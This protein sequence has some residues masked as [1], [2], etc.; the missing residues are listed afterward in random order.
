MWVRG[1]FEKGRGDVVRM[2]SV[3]MGHA[4]IIFLFKIFM[5]TTLKTQNV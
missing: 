5:N 2:V 3:R 1:R 4:V